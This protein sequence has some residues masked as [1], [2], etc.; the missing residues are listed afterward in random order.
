MSVQDI[1]DYFAEC[2]DSSID[3][4]ILSNDD[5]IGRL[6]PLG[7]H[8]VDEEASVSDSEIIIDPEIQ[9]QMGHTK[10]PSSPIIG[11]FNRKKGATNE[12]D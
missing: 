12:K 2:E 5:G 7:Y 6:I 10:E 9:D 3:S 8:G 11:F 1:E 4:S